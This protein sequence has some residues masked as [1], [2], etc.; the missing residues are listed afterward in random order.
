MNET[1]ISGKQCHPTAPAAWRVIHHRVNG[2]G[3]FAYRCHLCHQW[4]VTSQ[5]H[6]YRPVGWHRPIATDGELLY[7]NQE[8]R[9]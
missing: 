9:V 7:F 6:R 2:R 3:G 4:H 8:T 1:C 5:R